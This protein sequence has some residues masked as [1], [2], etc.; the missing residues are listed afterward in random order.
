M[1]D[2][3]TKVAHEGIELAQSRYGEDS[4]KG[5]AKEE[6]AIIYANLKISKMPEGSTFSPERLKIYSRRNLKENGC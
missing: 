6:I 2:F 3:S 5:S 1:E 4:G